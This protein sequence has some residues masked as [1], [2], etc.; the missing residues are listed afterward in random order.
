MLSLGEVLGC[1]ES[2]KA[3]HTIDLSDLCVTL[4]IFVLTLPL[5]IETVNDLHHNRWDSRVAVWA[6]EFGNHNMHVALAGRE[7]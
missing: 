5:E 6:G 4:D 3:L 1:F 2:C 7:G